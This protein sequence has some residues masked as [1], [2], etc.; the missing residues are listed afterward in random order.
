MMAR[1][2]DDA[3]ANHGL[4][5][6]THTHQ[7]PSCGRRPPGVQAGA[8]TPP[9]APLHHWQRGKATS[10]LPPRPLSSLLCNVSYDGCEAAPSYA[11]LSPQC[12][13]RAPRAVTANR[14]G[15]LVGSRGETRDQSTAENRGRLPSVILHLIPAQH[16]PVK[17]LIAAEDGNTHTKRSKRLGLFVV[18]GIPSPGGR[19]LERGDCLL[20]NSA[21]S[22]QPFSSFY[23]LF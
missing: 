13:P 12:S 11:P 2:A 23:G 5:P 16:P 10:F 17:M 7:S 22:L 3:S 15:D 21:L 19:A 1:F 20:R 9:F 18:E 6:N 14:H 8:W 4:R